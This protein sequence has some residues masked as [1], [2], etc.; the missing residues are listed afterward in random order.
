MRHA[1]A[2][3][4]RLFAAVLLGM[5]L[6]SSCTTTAPNVPTGEL[7]FQGSGYSVHIVRNGCDMPLAVIKAKAAVPNY[8][9]HRL[10]AYAGNTT[11]GIFG[12]NCSPAKAGG[13]AECLV[14]NE[15]IS[16]PDITAGE[17][18]RGWTN[19]DFARIG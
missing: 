16:N 13:Q 4:H 17:F 8:T 18:C 9:F 15:S 2:S 6:L 14:R 7:D 1:L 3:R 12:V 19:F 11:S 10:I 5:P